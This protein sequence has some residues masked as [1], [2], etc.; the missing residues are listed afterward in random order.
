MEMVP[1]A[2]L[3]AFRSARK[4]YRRIRRQAVFE[5]IYRENLWGDAESRSGS[6]SGL[7]ATEKIRNG[8]LETI[9]RLKIQTM[10]DAPC[11]D[12]YWLSKVDLAKHL[13]SYTGFD[14]VP[15]MIARNR[16]TWATEK[17]SFEEAD[18]IKRV[19]PRADLILCR[20]LLIH[21][22]FEDCL[23]LL[24]NFKSS[25]SRYLMITNSPLIERNEEILFTGSFRPVNLY[26]APFQFPPPIWS[27][28]ESQGED[29]TEAAVFELATLTI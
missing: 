28:D 29:R 23:R 15:Q 24:R 3:T 21:L 16:Q 12:F 9:E 20:H 26:V 5:Q 17:I 8:L 13:A 1:A 11:G 7:A 14:I 2:A 10:I 4:L 6:G 27:V 22:P 18:L 25:G 19:P